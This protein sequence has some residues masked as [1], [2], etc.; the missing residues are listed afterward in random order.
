M[1]LPGTLVVVVVEVD[2]VD[3]VEIDVDVDVEVVVDELEELE[4]DE[5]LVELPPAVIVVVSIGLLA[6]GVKAVPLWFAEA[7]AQHV[8]GTLIAPLIF[9]LMRRGA[10]VLSATVRLAAV[11]VLGVTCASENVMLPPVGVHVVLA[12]GIG[13]VSA[14]TRTVP[15]RV[16]S[17]LAA[18]GVEMAE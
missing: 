9:G 5:P 2:V 11:V 8:K 3:V 13:T 7:P 12:R 6:P 15:V 18:G 17:G 10:A 16:G 1:V 4:V 14:P